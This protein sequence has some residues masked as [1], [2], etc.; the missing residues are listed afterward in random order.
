MSLMFLRVRRAG[1]RYVDTGSPSGPVLVALHGYPDS[2]LVF[3]RLFSRLPKHR[4]I[5]LDWPGQGLSER[6]TSS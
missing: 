6:V 5:A 2:C 4:A 1:V 3:E